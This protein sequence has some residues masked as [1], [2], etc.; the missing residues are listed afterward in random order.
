MWQTGEWCWI[1]RQFPLARLLF[2]YLW[3]FV[4]FGCILFFAIRVACFV[5]TGMNT[6]VRQSAAGL[7]RSKV[8]LS[9]VTCIVTCVVTSLVTPLVTCV[10]LALFTPSLP[11]ELKTR[12]FRQLALYPIVFALCWVPA[13]VARFVEVF[14]LK[15]NHDLDMFLTSAHVLLRSLAG[16]FNFIIFV[17]SSRYSKGVHRARQG[18]LLLGCV[19]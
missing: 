5:R 13:T 4:S 8:P 7:Q 17:V 10:H 15:R 19:C 1:E 6:S 14:D 2:F 11:Q 16:F 9:P 12:L 3:T 18:T